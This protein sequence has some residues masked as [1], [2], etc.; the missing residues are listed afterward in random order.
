MEQQELR[1][2]VLGPNLRILVALFAGLVLSAGSAS[3]QS[4]APARSIVRIE[5]SEQLFVMMCALYA[6]GYPG[7]MSANGLPYFRAQ[8]REDLL[9]RQGPSIDALREY[10]QDHLLADSSETLSRYISFALVVGPPPD[11][12]F[13]YNREELPPDALTLEGLRE[14][15]ANFY[16]EQ[17]LDRLWAQAAPEYEKQ[18]ARLRAPVSRLIA[19]AAAYLREVIPAASA[20]SFVVYVEPLVGGATN[21][22][23][24]GNEYAIVISPGAEPPLADIRHA[25]LHFLLDPLPL[26]YRSVVQSRQALLAYAAPAPRL[27]EEYRQDF[28]ALLTECL[29]RAVELRVERLAPAQAEAS[30]GADERDGYVLIRPLYRQ[31][32]KFEQ[33][34]PGMTRYFPDLIKGIDVAAEERRLQGFHFAAAEAGR[35]SSSNATGSHG[36]DSEL[37]RW[38]EEGNRLIAAQDGRGAAAIFERILAKYPNTPRALYGLAVASVL[39]GDG[40]RAHQFFEQLVAGASTDVAAGGS[41][42]SSP[43]EPEIVA[44]SRVYLGRMGDL[45]GDRELALKQYRAALAVEGAPEAARKAAQRGIEQ[46]YKPP[47]KGRETGQPQR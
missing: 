15:L 8:L 25:F 32:E 4:P 18:A 40:G 9:R 28:S 33:S 26:R 42:G 21:F 37:A 11:F 19:V 47:Q 41:A 36:E 17:H 16:T 43:Q 5:S 44:W 23:S 3:A 20:R 24:Y 30:I 31:L 12:R 39:Q 2:E 34:E 10:Y 14:T 35:A 7:D 22:R 45:E 29:V 1:V 6:A 38:L 46:A 27:A 13:R